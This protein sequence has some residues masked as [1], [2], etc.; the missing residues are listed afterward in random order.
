MTR[1]EGQTLERDRGGRGSGRA[2][3]EGSPR[4]AANCDAENEHGD[5]SCDSQRRLDP[6]AHDGLSSGWRHARIAPVAR[7]M[8]QFVEHDTR[9]ADVAQAPF[10]VAIETALEQASQPR[11]RVDGQRIPVDLLAQHR[12]EH[13]GTLLAR[14]YA[15]AGQHLENDEAE[16]PDVDPAIDDLAAG[17]L[18]GHVGRGAEDQP[19]LCAAS[20]ERRRERGAAVCRRARALRG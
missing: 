6:R 19:H 9:L 15:P 17:L 3:T 11:G 18:G 13:V 16:G 14:E 2:G 7:I 10:R 12:G 5:G 4:E 8:R 1:L 20:R